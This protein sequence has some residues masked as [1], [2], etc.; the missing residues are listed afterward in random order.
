MSRRLLEGLSVCLTSWTSGQES[1]SLLGLSR[2]QLGKPPHGSQ[3]VYLLYTS[4][5]VAQV[6][7]LPAPCHLVAS[8][9]PRMNL[10]IRLQPD[11][12]KITILENSR[13]DSKSSLWCQCS[14]E[15]PCLQPLKNAQWIN[16]NGRVSSAS[17]HMCS[18]FPKGTGELCLTKHRPASP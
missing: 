2:T 11:G 12:H 17:L 14:K 13:D 9:D 5:S 15:Q 3:V 8:I 10:I 6:N 18:L 1:G 16:G 7:T 4:F